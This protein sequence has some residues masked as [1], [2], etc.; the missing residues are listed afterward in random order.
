MF[1]AARLRSTR[2]SAT[3]RALGFCLMAALVLPQPLAAQAVVQRLPDPAAAD[4]SD[5]LRR[6]G[7]DPQSLSALIDAGRASLR[8]ED[9]E[10]AAGFYTRAQAIAPGD[11][12]VLAGLAQVALA[13]QD[14]VGALQLFDRAA[15]QGEPLDALAGQRGLAYDLVGMNTRAQVLYGQALGRAQDPET[16]RRLALSY[17]I[18]GD[19]DASEATLLPLLQAQDL[20]AYRTRA[21]ALAIAGQADE[22]VSIA[23]TRLPPRIAQ[24]LGPYLRY[25]PRLTRAQQAAAANFGTFPHPEAIGRDDPTIAAY[26]AG[27]PLPQLAQGGA[28]SRLIPGGQPLGPTVQAAPGGE[29]PPTSAAATAPPPE[30]AATTAPAPAPAPSSQAPVTMAAAAPAELPPVGAASQPPATLAAAPPVDVPAAPGAAT[31]WGTSEA[32]LQQAA[33]PAPAAGYA[34]EPAAAPARPASPPAV[35]RELAE[36]FSDFEPTPERPTRPVSP[37]VVDITRIVPAREAPPTPPPPFQPAA[38]PATPRL[39]VNPSRHWVQ[40]ATGQDVANFR[41]DWMR[42]ARFAKDLLSGKQPF[43]AAWGVNNRLVT[44]PFASEAEAQGLVT[45]LAAGGVSSFVFTSGNGER[46]IPLP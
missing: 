17:A 39:P 18:G 45:R 11:G 43:Y 13:R 7:S 29:L 2:G 14:A 22:A 28:D 1:P 38:E 36:V 25:M 40:V 31:S 12:R 16:V 15:A 3:A 8:L 32:P 30:L 19:R 33:A 24:R 46:V 10:A 41:Y 21:F 35:R 26:S 6:L 44:G 27:E 9:V 5:A 4:L 34:V 20:A 42:I 23:E 37:D